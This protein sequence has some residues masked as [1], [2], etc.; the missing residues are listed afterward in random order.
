MKCLEGEAVVTDEK[1][2]AD[3]CKAEFAAEAQ[4]FEWVFGRSRLTQSVKWG[5]IWRADF[6]TPGNPWA[7]GS[8]VNRAMC[9]G[10]AG[11]VKGKAIAF[12]QRI[13]PLD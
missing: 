6:F 2:F 7:T 9:W 3:I 1:S 8:L 10:D 13:P 11:V 4:H 12:G 5:L